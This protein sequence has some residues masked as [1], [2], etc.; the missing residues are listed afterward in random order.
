MFGSVMFD[1]LLRVSDP[2]VFRLT[3]QK[4]VGSGKAYGFG[5]LSIAPTGPA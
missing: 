1:G 5:L 2:D 3:L 4:G